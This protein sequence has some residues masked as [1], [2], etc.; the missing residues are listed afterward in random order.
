MEIISLREK[1][2]YLNRA[3]EFFQRHWA[4]DKSRDVY[5]D[6]LSHAVSLRPA[7][8][9]WYMLIDDGNII[10]GAGLITNDFISRMDLT[11]W[12]CALVVEKEFRGRG[13]AGLIID[14]VK[15]DAESMEYKALYLCTD[16]DGFYERFGFK[17]IGRGY[18][19]WGESSVIYE[20]VFGA[21]SRD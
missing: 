18:H 15:R 7:L 8:P 19:P 6:C 3:V 11:P 5:E 16:L 14:R 10:G 13:L 12:L 9:Q 17:R 2:E 1:P 20:F 21:G 4:T